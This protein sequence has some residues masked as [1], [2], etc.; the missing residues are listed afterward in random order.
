MVNRLPI[1]SLLIVFLVCG[2]CLPQQSGSNADETPV[3]SYG[4]AGGLLAEFPDWGMPP[5]NSWPEESMDMPKFRGWYRFLGAMPSLFSSK[6]ALT[7]DAVITDSIS[8]ME[9]VLSIT[10]YSLESGEELWR[11]DVPKVFELEMLAADESNVYY[12]NEGI[13]TAISLNN[14]EVLWSSNR[15]LPVAA[16]GDKIW[17][18]EYESSAEEENPIGIALLSAHDG[19][20]IYGVNLGEILGAGADYV[21]K[22]EHAGSFYPFPV[23]ASRLAVKTRDEI[24]VYQID[25]TKKSYPA[26]FENRGAGFLFEGDT[27]FVSEY[28]DP[29]EHARIPGADEYYAAMN[30]RLMDLIS[31]E[32]KW[33]FD[34]EGTGFNTWNSKIYR[35]RDA[36]AICMDS[37]LLAF[38]AKNGNS[39][40]EFQPDYS[41]PRLSD[42]S[43]GEFG[44]YTKDPFCDFSEAASF[45][46]LFPQS[47]VP[48]RKID[49]K[50]NVEKSAVSNKYFVFTGTT[51][52]M[53]HSFWGANGHL[54]VAEIGADGLPKDG[55]LKIAYAH[56]SNT[57]LVDRF[58]S[59]AAPSS[60]KDLMREI[61]A[62]GAKVYR[63][64]LNRVGEATPRQLDDMIALAVYLATAS[65]REEEFLYPARVE[66]CNYLK[67][68]LN[69]GM[70]GQIIKWMEDDTLTGMRPRLIGLLASAGG[71][72]AKGYLDVHYDSY[73]KQSRLTTDGPYCLVKPEKVL[74]RTEKRIEEIDDVWCETTGENNI[75]Y[76]TYISPGLVS[77]RD[78]YIAIDSDGDGL[79][80]E[81]LPTGLSDVYF[82][83]MHPGGI[84]GL[85]KRLGPLHISVEGDDVFLKHHEP[86]INEQK[87][88]EGKED[89]YSFFRVVNADYVTTKLSLADLRK[90]TD[91][92][93]LTDI[94][95]LMLL[96]NP[97]NIDS[98]G[99]GIDDY[100]DPYPNVNLTSLGAD[101]RAL[102]RALGYFCNDLRY[103][104]AETAVEGH[105]WKANFIGVEGATGVGMSTSEDVFCISLNAPEMLDQFLI[106]L[107]GYNYDSLVSAMIYG[108]SA[109]IGL[110][111]SGYQFELTEIGGEWYP[112]Q[113]QLSWIS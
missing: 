42:N 113:S 90:D 110:S 83:N 21:P 104:R 53:G 74:G 4:E 20:E 61:V 10:S 106:N 35:F 16:C 46:L 81:V 59:S 112:V 88:N 92:D 75:R 28:F 14:G 27:L 101:D 71:E 98:D 25:G 68:I 58:Y 8:H 107:K 13:V 77:A 76:L 72:V 41:G 82:F 44:I 103:Y 94:L 40:F 38:N 80:E 2:T 85:K 69:P 91:G 111:L 23:D 18:L 5:L 12:F 96:T 32:T 17:A 3:G 86:E 9:K 24:H 45:G 30:L 63:P 87:Y 15:Y 78:I 55:E 105:P 100:N 67:S 51:E 11:H 84:G 95:E 48:F 49:T 73:T 109:Y 19:N 102:S 6:L 97:D 52:P 60:N 33:D 64:L 89:E 43:H 99:D 37:G 66:F 65:G 47:E 39:V 108:N 50:C 57:D 93:G 26:L 29:N 22:S 54:V 1:F 79:Y 34:F 7:N 62:L 70:S 56:E 31:G 36:V